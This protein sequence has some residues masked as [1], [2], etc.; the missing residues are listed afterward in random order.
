MLRFQPLQRSIRF[1]RVK[2]REGVLEKEGIALFFH[3]KLPIFYFLM[4]EK[5]ENG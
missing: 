3:K 5:I 4:R 2:D 1:M